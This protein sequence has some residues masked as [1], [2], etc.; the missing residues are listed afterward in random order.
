PNNAKQRGI[1]YVLLMTLI[2]SLLFVA[3]HPLNALTINKG[4]Q[5]IFLNPY[6]LFDTLC[7]GM[8]CSLSYIYSRSLWVPI[9]IHWLT[10]VLWVMFFGGRNLILE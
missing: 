2:S 10:V 6:F 8:A 9:I 7:L 1:K 5:E 4:A 3:W